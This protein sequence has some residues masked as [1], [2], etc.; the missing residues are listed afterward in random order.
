MIDLGLDRISPEVDTHG[1]VQWGVAL[2][3]CGCIANFTKDWRADF[4]I[5]VGKR[6]RDF[7]W[8]VAQKNGWACKEHRADVGRW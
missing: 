3:R 8:H 4:G 1:W 6:W 7:P 5:F 2:F